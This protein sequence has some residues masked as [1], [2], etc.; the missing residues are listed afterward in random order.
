MAKKRKTTSKTKSRSELKKPKTAKPENYF[1]LVTGVPLKNLKELALA[2]ETMNDWVF[3]HHV[4]DSRNDFSSWIQHVLNEEELAEE[5][6]L[7]HNPRDLEVIILR[8][9]A[10]KYL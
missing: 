2:C 5:I 7:A 3:N 8:Y 4:N 6:K 1:I 9:L 10:N